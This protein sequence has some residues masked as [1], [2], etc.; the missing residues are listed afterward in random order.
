MSEL[1]PYHKQIERDRKLLA[2][3]LEQREFAQRALD[4]ANR[5]IEYLSNFLIRATVEL[6]DEV[7]DGD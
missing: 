4:T 7:S 2:H 5:Q 3:W 1:S 6:P